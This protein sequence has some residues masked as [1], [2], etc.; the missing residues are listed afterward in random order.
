MTLKLI[1]IEA[2]IIKGQL[3]AK[4]G[5]NI[6]QRQKVKCQLKVCQIEKLKISLNDVPQDRHVLLI[7]FFNSIISFI[8]NIRKGTKKNYGKFR[9]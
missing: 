1:P 6:V 5:K 4:I 8:N 2:S 7:N 9:N 3:R